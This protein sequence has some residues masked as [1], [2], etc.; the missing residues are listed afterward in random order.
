MAVVVI[1]SII[2]GFFVIG[3][4]STQRK[5]RDDHTRIND[6][7]QIQ[8]GIANYYDAKEALPE[9][10]SDLNDAFSGGYVENDPKTGEAYE[11]TPLG[12]TQ[13]ELCATFELASPTIDEDKADMGDW[14]V[15]S[16]MQ[17][18]E[19]WGHEAERTCF[20]RE[21]DEDIYGIKPVR[22]ID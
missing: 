1:A 13:F 15:R 18:N 14:Q 12:G 2:A 10:L 6:L 4:P 11:Y 21:V 19:E 20:T 7:Q 22:L 17:E 16:L 9:S 5:Y 8:F 3:T